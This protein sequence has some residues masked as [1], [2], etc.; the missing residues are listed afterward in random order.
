MATLVATP[1]EIADKFAFKSG[2]D[3]K[4]HFKRSDAALKEIEAKYPV[5]SFPFADGHAIYAVVSKSP[6]KLMHIP[7]G[8][9]WQIGAPTIRGLRL[10]DVEAMIQREKALRSIFAK[11]GA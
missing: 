11:K 3:Y 5:L 10:A 6:L 2:G 1:K 7:F 9:A 4:E 8:D